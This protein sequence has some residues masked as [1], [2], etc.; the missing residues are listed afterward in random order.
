MPASKAPVVV[1]HPLRDADAQ[2]AGRA[3]R[4]VTIRGKM[5]LHGR[6]NSC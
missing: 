5:G 4:D 2:P 3:T 6:E 1:D